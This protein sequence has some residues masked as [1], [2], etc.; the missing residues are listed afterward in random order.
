[1]NIDSHYHLH[2]KKL[3][4]KNRISAAILLLGLGGII[5]S[6]FL[7]PKVFASTALIEGKE[8][9]ALNS[10]L[11]IAFSE[12]MIP[13]TFEG[14]ISIYPQ[15]ELKF[16][17]QNYN[18]ELAVYPAYSWKPETEYRIS[19]HG[20]RN[21]MLV[22]RD[23]SFVFRTINYPKVAGFFPESGSKNVVLDIEDPIAVTFQD[24]IKDFKIKITADPPVALESQVDME[25]NRVALIPKNELAKG[26]KYSL[27]VSIKGN[28]EADSA[29]RNV[30]N[31]DF[32]TKPDPPQNWDKDFALRLEQAKLF[33]Q[34]QVK[35]GKY[36]DIN[37]KSQVM[38]IFEN[39]KL[40]DA[41][42]ISSGKRGLE[43]PQ[44]TF[45]IANKFPRAWSKAYGLFMPYWMALVPSGKFGIHEL[46]EWPSGYKEGAAHLG[47]PVSHGCVRLGVGPAERVYGWAEVGTPVVVHS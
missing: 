47:I 9:L 15:T 10:P 14:G 13:Q 12:S 27:A 32:T 36:I 31:Y 33:T 16:R 23:F 40:L 4:R 30:L 28:N 8:K 6:L 3:R 24:S 1:M 42:M 21:I 25:K 2:K 41:F 26:Q 5:S 43:T 17:W 20:V 38:T 18:R 19:L 35:E 44:G 45:H 39:G 7:Y 11:V 22:A 37:L 29:Y 34:P 46:P